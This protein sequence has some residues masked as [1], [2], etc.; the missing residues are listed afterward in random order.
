MHS[1]PS[2]IRSP[3]ARPASRAVVAA[4]AMVGLLFVLVLALA[5]VFA[6]QGRRDAQATVETRAA[7]AA[8]TASTHVRWLIEANQQAL[9]RVAD[10]VGDRLDLFK[11]PSMQDLNDAVSSLPGS[12]HIWVFDAN[13]DSVMTNEPSLGPANVAHRPYFQALRDGAAWHI[14][15][16]LMGERSGV[17]LFPLGRRI[18]RDGRFVGAV[19]IYV[20][21]DLLAQFWASLDLGPGSTVG[22]LRDDGW[23]V[24]RHPVPDAPLDLSKYV[25][26]TDHLKVAPQGVYHADA[27]PA[28]GIARVVGYR[29]VDGLPLVTVV[30]IPFRS[31]DDSVWQRLG[32]VAVAAAPIAA[33]LLAVSLWVVR[34]LHREERVRAALAGALEQNR[35]LFR[36]IH[37]RV[38]NNLQTVSALVHLQPGPPEAKE[39][40]MRRIAAMSAV[41]EHIYRSDRYDR[42]D[43]AEYIRTLVAGLRDGYGSAVAVECRLAPLTVDA[44]LALPLGLIVNEAVSNAFKHAF[45]DGRPGVIAVSLEAAGDDRAVLRVQDDGVGY[46]PAARGTGMGSRLIRSLAQQIGGGH[47]FRDENGTLF[48]LDFPL[49]RPG[50]AAARPQAAA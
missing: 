49:D 23:L 21:A 7:A 36:E 46:A 27:S 38:K 32:E 50:S 14:G 13:G 47:A 30:G 6:W 22:L 19:V 3:E 26:F 11:T 24:A 4:S 42:V 31:L 10:S 35:T 12:V 9:S 5:A 45:P 8:Y 40:L 29:R 15:P 16:F 41:H 17:K 37:H 44:D 43:V 2:P 20:P 25:L 34:L 39:E 18:E 48:V 28:D 1:G 33:A